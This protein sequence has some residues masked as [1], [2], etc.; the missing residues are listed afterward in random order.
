M[1]LVNETETKAEDKPADPPASE[2]APEN[3]E[4]K[5]AAAA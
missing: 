5:P 3:K 2:T 4:N 1:L